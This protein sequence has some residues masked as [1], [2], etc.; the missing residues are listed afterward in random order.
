MRLLM[1]TPAL[2][3]C[4]VACGK[5]DDSEAQ[6]AGRA[7]T[8]EAISSNDVTAI[9][10]VTGEA[11]NMAEDVELTLEMNNAADGANAGGNG[12]ASRRRPQNSAPASAPTTNTAAPAPQPAA[13]ADPQANT[14]R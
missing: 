5:G 10:A 7:L 11:A 1:L 4:L 3:L 12:S 6:N 14:A 13:P 2:A 9:D 8:A